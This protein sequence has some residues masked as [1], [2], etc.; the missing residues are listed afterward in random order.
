MIKIKTEYRS[1]IRLNLQLLI[2]CKEKDYPI[3]WI[4]TTSALFFPYFPREFFFS[5]CPLNNVSFKY[6]NFLVTGKQNETLILH[7]IHK[8]EFSMTDS[9]KEKIEKRAYELFLKRGG[10]H[11]YAMQ[12]WAQAEKEITG[13]GKSGKKVEAK[14]APA[15]APKPII[16]NVKKR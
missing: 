2:I 15:P 4:F 6:F 14:A 7:T 1:P 5:F 8:G 13:E 16:K 3:H 11:G 10:V 12:D 9:L